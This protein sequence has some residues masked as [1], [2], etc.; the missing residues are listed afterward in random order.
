MHDTTHTVAQ[1]HEHHIVTP[2][3]YAKVLIGL[4]ILMALTIFAARIH[5][6]GHVANLAIALLIAIS[7]MTLIMLY[8]MHVKFSSK[9]VVAFAVGGFFWLLIFFVFTFSDFTTR[10]WISPFTVSPYGG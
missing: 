7:K 6:G 10:G 4:M 9:L 3:T 8:F 2:A 1:P 5:F